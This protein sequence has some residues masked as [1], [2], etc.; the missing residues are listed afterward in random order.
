MSPPTQTK[1]N[2]GNE[3]IVDFVD[4]SRLL[5][6]SA[7]SYSYAASD[8][9][10]RDMEVKHSPFTTTDKQVRFSEDNCFHSIRHQSKEELFQ[11][12]HSKEDK[13]LF[14]KEL[15]RDV[16]SIRH[17]LSSTPMEE[18][19]KE[20]LYWCLGLEVLVS[21]QVTRLV[22]EMKVEHSRSIVQIQDY[23]SDEQLAAYAMR[24]SLQSRERA[25]NLAAGNWEI[26]P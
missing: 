21:I 9:K 7:T 19:E 22:R 24:S 15:A 8:N 2:D 25:H 10:D 20:V 18:L 5:P 17:L 12:W 16:Q 4:R 3:L 13:F 11:R 1:A 26:L 6:L 14:K 23:L